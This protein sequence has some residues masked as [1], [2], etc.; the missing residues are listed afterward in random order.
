MRQP[1]MPTLGQAWAELKKYQRFHHKM[2]F[3]LH[4]SAS[5]QW[6]RDQEHGC[7][8]GAMSLLKTIKKLEGT[9]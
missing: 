8:M 1:H 4:D 9:S 5:H 2:A 3:F 6:Q 7:R